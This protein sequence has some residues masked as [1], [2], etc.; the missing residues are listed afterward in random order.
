MLAEVGLVKARDDGRGFYDRF[1]DRLMFPIY[2]VMGR[3]VALGGR[4]LD[5]LPEAPKYLN[6]PETAIYKKGTL[7]YGLHLAKQ[8]IRAEGRVLI[9][10]GYLDLISLFQAGIEHVVATLGTALTRSHVQLLKAYAKEA[11]LVFDGD[12]AGRSAALRGKEYFL[13]GHVRY[14]LPS[15]HVS[16][17][18]G[19]WKGTCMPKWCCYPR[20]TTPIRLF[21]PRDA[22]PCSPRCGRHSRLSNFCSM[23]RPR[24]TIWLRFKANSPMCASFC[25]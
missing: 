3:V 24:G 17:F 23:L 5:N 16:S 11:V 2:N 25:H 18:R 14:F 9:V 12:T 13:Q 20:A 7:L 22:M 8:P 19:H 10:E 21:R 6:S 4:L 1:R 15:A